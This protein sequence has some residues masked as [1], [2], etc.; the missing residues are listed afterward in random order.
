MDKP[1]RVA[2]TIEAKMRGVSVGQ[3][4]REAGLETVVS[5]AEVY[6]I[7]TY[8]WTNTKRQLVDHLNAAVAEIKRLREARDDGFNAGWTARRE[9]DEST[10]RCACGREDCQHATTASSGPDPE[11]GAS[12]FVPLPS[13]PDLREQN[14]DVLRTKAWRLC[15][16]IA[17]K[18]AADGLAVSGHVGWK[19][20]MDADDEFMAALKELRTACD[21]RP[22]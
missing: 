12:L 8:R 19:E 1:L 10:S 16:A 6:V 20:Q 18:S 15:E 9:T 13:E 4:L 21:G 5:T 3:V 11:T 7:P 22:R 14:V 17:Q 2:L